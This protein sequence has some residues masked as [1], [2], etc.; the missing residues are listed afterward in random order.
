MN[1]DKHEIEALPQ[2]HRAALINSL[3][4]YKPVVLVGTADSNGHTNLS[5]INSCFQSAQPLPFLA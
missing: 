4:G 3:P 5:A 1:L 2:R